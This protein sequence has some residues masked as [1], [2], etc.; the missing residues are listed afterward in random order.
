MFWPVVVTTV[1]CVACS[2]QNLY[3]VVGAKLAAWLVRQLVRQPVAFFSVS[4]YR[5]DL[6]M[7]FGRNLVQNSFFN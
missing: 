2:C 7:R 5:R 3:C 1:G 6:V 4:T